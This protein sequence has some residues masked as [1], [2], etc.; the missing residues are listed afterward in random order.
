MSLERKRREE[1]A[2]EEAL[3]RTALEA[4]M[5]A[6]VEQ[7]KLERAERDRAK[8]EEYERKIEQDEE[9]KRAETERL[10]REKF[11][12]AEAERKKREED[13]ARRR[14]DS[15]ETD[16]RRAELKRLQKSGRIRSPL[17]RMRN[18]GIGVVAVVALIVGAIHTMPMSGYIP[19]VE[20]MVADSLGE[21][22]RI[23]AMQMSVVSGLQFK[24]SD[25][26]IGTIQDVSLKEVLVTP[27]FDS[28]F[29]DKV[30]VKSIRA[31]GGIVM[32]EALA[33][34]PAWL[35]DSIANEALRVREI[36]LRGVKLD[37]RALTLPSL[38]V[39]VNFDP[40]GRIVSAAVKTADG[41]LSADINNRSGLSQVVIRATN[42]SPP[43]GA[44][45]QLDDFTGTGTIK[46]STLIL[47]E[48][49]ATTYG[50]QAKGTGAISWASRWRLTSEF[51]FSRV[52]AEALLP[53]FSKTA[54]VTG[55]AS[56]TASLTAESGGIDALLDRPSLQASFTVSKGTVHGVDLVRALQAGRAGS[57]GGSTRF[58]ELTGTVSV[59]NRRFSYSNVKLSAGILSAQSSFN[60][61]SNQDLSG[62]VSVGLRSPVQL[63]SANLN[64]SGDLNGP[65]L[66]P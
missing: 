52:D 32:M 46:G 36:N 14:K 62:W 2:R 60:I 30:T 9:R 16:R 22:V 7:E 48:W 50:G 34:M 4:E 19:A 44:P 56:G 61:S 64:V 21:P 28:L 31:D 26:S 29:G 55:N 43:I 20:R 24:F 38:N 63:L 12:R 54:K 65:I 47:N 57:Q 45:V 10:E 27:Q 15:E 23:G 42:W 66:K 49:D 39:D 25:V 3:R 8:R 41:K 37:M 33:R 11:E 17:E 6:R 5:R 53:V 51:E 58:E 13:L 1:E 59:A 40:D 18:V 35:G